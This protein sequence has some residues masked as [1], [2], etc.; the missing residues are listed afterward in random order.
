MEVEPHLK[1]YGRTRYF[2]IR[3]TVHRSGSQIPERG[4]RADAKNSQWVNKDD[5]KFDMVT[6][7][8]NSQVGEIASRINL[9]G[10]R[11]HGLPKNVKHMSYGVSRIIAVTAH[12]GL[13]PPTIWKNP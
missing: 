3:D 12:C 11:S 5:S 9:G 2:Q 4:F 10:N 7:F 6:N 8:A 13:K 1:E